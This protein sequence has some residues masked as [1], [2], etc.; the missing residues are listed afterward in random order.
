MLVAVYT[1]K[2]N[3]DVANICAKYDHIKQKQKCELTNELLLSGEFSANLFNY[4]IKQRM[5]VEYF[6][7][8]YTKHTNVERNRFIVK[9]LL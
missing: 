6:S 4:T 8:T 2:V 3:T 7:S 1:L 9:F 5:Y